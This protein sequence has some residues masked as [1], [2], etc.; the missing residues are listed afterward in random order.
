MKTPLSKIE[1]LFESII[2]KMDQDTRVRAGL[3]FFNA[4]A[5]ERRRRMLWVMRF[6]DEYRRVCAIDIFGTGLMLSDIKRVIEADI[7]NMRAD[8]HFW[9]YDDESVET[10]ERYSVL[11]GPW[12]ALL[13]EYLVETE[14][15]L[16]G[17]GEA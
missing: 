8:L 17:L 4:N 9:S 1:A 5:R 15:N 2:P 16:G 14:A 6:M 7:F 13:E 11:H 3:S 10:R 12:K